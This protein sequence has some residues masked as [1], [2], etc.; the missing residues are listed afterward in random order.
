MVGDLSLTSGVGM[1]F[2]SVGPVGL[3]LVGS[4]VGSL[5]VVVSCT[6]GFSPPLG[7][8]TCSFFFYAFGVG[9][10]PSVSK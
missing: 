5:Y 2:P 7:E 9:L 1:V 4:F 3:S 10:L 8:S 6:R